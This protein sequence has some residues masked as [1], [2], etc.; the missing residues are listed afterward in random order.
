ML[1]NIPKDPILLLSFLNT[2]LR[3]CYC[4]LDTLCDDLQLEKEVVIS[5][6]KTIDY[7]YDFK[8]NQFI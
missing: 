5:K 3:D 2:K 4:N 8:T 6:L 7:E 1:N